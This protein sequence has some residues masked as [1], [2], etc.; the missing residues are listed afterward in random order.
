MMIME[1]TGLGEYFKGAFR[2][3]AKTV[4]VFELEMTI[5]LEFDRLYMNEQE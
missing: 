1:E 2:A 4:Q 3:V 5:H